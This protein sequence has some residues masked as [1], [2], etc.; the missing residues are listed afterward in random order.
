MRFR[1]PHDDPTET[2]ATT[3]R[4]Q[5]DEPGPIPT[6][7]E[8]RL[9]WP[10]ASWKVVAGCQRFAQNEIRTEL[11]FGWVSPRAVPLLKQLKLVRNFNPRVA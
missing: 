4:K 1:D 11:K 7:A 5:Q 9:I 3:K 10:R 2:E 6:L 8:L